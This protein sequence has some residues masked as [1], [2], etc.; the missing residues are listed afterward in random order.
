MSLN[1][2]LNKVPADVEWADVAFNDVKTQTLTAIQF[3]A[4]NLEVKGNLQ[5]DNNTDTKGNVTM[6]G[7]GGVQIGTGVAQKDLNVFGNINQFPPGTA[8]TVRSIITLGDITPDTNSA[9]DI[10]GALL[11]FKT[12]FT[13][14]ITQTAAGVA[15]LKNVGADSVTFNGPNQ[16][17][18]STYEEFTHV[19]TFSGPWAAPSPPLNVKLTRIGS[20]VHF[21]IPFYSAAGA[22]LSAILMDT[23]LPARFRPNDTSAG[24][25]AVYTATNNVTQVVARCRVLNTGAATFYGDAGT[26]V[27]AAAGTAAMNPVCIDYS[28]L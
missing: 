20:I 22:N 6:T 24:I 16:S 27:F 3:S 14:N 1:Q 10:G 28:T 19:T 13:D 8:T 18:L 25:D 17:L 7:P 21:S 9:H 5:V 11:P 15:A 4:I 12:L 2:V 23:L 26:A